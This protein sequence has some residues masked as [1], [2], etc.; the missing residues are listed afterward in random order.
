MKRISGSLVVC[1]G[2]G[3]FTA[4]ALFR[5]PAGRPAPAAAASTAGTGTVTYGTGRPAGGTAAVA[6]LEIADFA[7]GDVTAAP[8]AAVDL[9]NRDGADHTV[10]AED[11]DFDVAIAGGA[12]GSFTAPAAPGTYAFFCAIHPQMKG[13]L[14]VR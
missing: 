3:L 8:G 6:T 5:E 12:S 7:F 10:T 4:G 9:V 2:A 13:T 11:G 1:V 14:V